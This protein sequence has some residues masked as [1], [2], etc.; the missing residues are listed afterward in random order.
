[1]YFVLQAIHRTHLKVDFSERFQLLNTLFFN[2]LFFF[3]LISNKMQSAI[4]CERIFTKGNVRSTANTGITTTWN[5]L[6]KFPWRIL[7]KLAYS[8][9]TLV[10]LK[11]HIRG[12]KRKKLY[13]KYFEQFYGL[14]FSPVNSFTWIFKTRD[15][16]KSLDNVSAD[17]NPTLG[18]KW[19]ILIM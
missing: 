7:S 6:K 8:R 9:N 2:F 17:N 5:C 14:F 12:G 1:M 19:N 16:R 15:R 4:S 10:L 3:I 11:W 13:K 18:E